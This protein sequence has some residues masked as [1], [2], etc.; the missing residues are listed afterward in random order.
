VPQA[1][2]AFGSNIGNRR[3]NIKNA[4]DKMK[5]NGLNI[6]KVSTTIETAPY[7]Y[8]EQDSFLNGACIV[9]TDLFPKELLYKLLSIEQEMGR[10][11]K[12]HWGPRNIDL[13]IIFYDDQIINE[14]DL[15]IPHPDAHN[16]SFVMG[17]VSEIAPFFIH[18]VYKKTVNEIYKE[19]LN[20]P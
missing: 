8:K 1:I 19:L 16:R 18:P 15:I 4:L 7:G 5:N 11:R 10:K 9:E 3:E 2:I 20:R 6:L 13:D 17:P 14:E 12:I